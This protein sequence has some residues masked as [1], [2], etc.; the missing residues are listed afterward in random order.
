M[1]RKAKQEDFSRL[2]LWNTGKYV[3]GS[4]RIKCNRETCTSMTSIRE[5]DFGFYCRE[6]FFKAPECSTDGCENPAIQ[7]PRLDTE[8]RCRSCE[9]EYE[10]EFN[11]CTES[12]FS[13]FEIWANGN[14]A[15]N[16]INAAA[17]KFMRKNGVHRPDPRKN[18]FPQER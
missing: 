8:G 3:N 5:F 17:D 9:F 13:Q 10:G 15:R 7:D 1:K 2:R 6:C 16:E 18:W 14:L 12:V 4:E 11:P